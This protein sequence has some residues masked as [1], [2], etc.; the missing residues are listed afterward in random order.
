MWSCPENMINIK[1]SIIAKLKTGEKL[2]NTLE[3]THV[4]SNNNKNNKFIK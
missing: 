3:S 4:L 1:L 2:Q